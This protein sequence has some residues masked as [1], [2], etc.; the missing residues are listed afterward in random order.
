MGFHHVVAIATAFTL[1]LGT[2]LAQESC[3]PT[4]TD[5]TCSACREGAGI[6]VRGCPTRALLSQHMPCFAQALDGIPRVNRDFVSIS[7]NYGDFDWFECPT[8]GE[9]LLSF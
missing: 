4:E 3:A 8:A 9:R 7:S 1:V 5:V 6:N 2:V